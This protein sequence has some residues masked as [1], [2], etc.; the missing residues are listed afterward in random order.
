MFSKKKKVKTI[1]I[2]AKEIVNN[3]IDACD[4]EAITGQLRFSLN[5]R[6]E[7]VS[8]Y[9]GISSSTVTR[10]KKECLMAG[11]SK[12]RT[13]GIHRTCRLSKIAQL[14]YLSV[15]IIRNI[16]SDFYLFKEGE[17]NSSILLETIKEKIDFPG[18]LH[19]LR[20]LLED[21]GFRWKKCRRR[22]YQ[23]LI[24]QPHLT[25]WRFRYLKSVRKAREEN[26]NI[27]YVSES[28][29]DNTLTF[30]KSWYNSDSASTLENI[31][32]S[33]SLIIFH[34]CKETGFVENVQL[35]FKPDCLRAYNGNIND[36]TYEKWL[37]NKLLPNIPQNSVIILDSSP[38]N[39]LEQN[40]IPSKYATKAAMIS[41]LE[42]NGVL[43][44]PD[45]YRGELFNLIT[46]YKKNEKVYIV[47]EMLKA[48]GHT[49]LRLPPYMCILNPAEL[50]WEKV[51]S[52]VRQKSLT[53]N[54]PLNLNTT[55]S[56]AMGSI[57]AEDWERF[58][59][60][61]IK[62]ESDYSSTDEAMEAEMDKF[63]C[64]LINSESSDTT[65]NSDSELA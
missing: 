19:T 48:E 32:R 15:H 4:K 14:D 9:A 2:A 12:L 51:E 64:T 24:E 21:M 34:A 65:S 3:V 44:S 54:S 26:K 57:T 52:K 62:I 36:E 46:K 45:M 16:I 40:K 63:I 17:V 43:I 59:S 60:E 55:V 49:I 42:K 56:E 25:M 41:W 50:A 38:Y 39:S 28:W 61:V 8:D 22:R 27:I 37:T 5:R 18:S 7:R 29:V 31:E 58:F 23:L 13:P 11:D 1:N 6:R 30:K 47:D 33:N 10:I 53:V 20:R 35:I